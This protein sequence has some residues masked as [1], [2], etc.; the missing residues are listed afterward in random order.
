MQSDPATPLLWHFPVSHY[1][2]KAR[3]ALDWKRI[4][5]RRKAL[6][7]DYIPRAFF[8][9]RQLSLP[10]LILGGKAVADSTRI[11]ATL[12]ERWRDPPLYPADPGLREEALALEDFFD[13]EVGHPV[14]TLLLGDLSV[15]GVD[16]FRAVGVRLPL[17]FDGVAVDVQSSGVVVAFLPPTRGNAPD[18]KASI[19]WPF[20]LLADA[21]L[22]LSG[23]IS[24]AAARA[25]GD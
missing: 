17:Q 18:T 16:R 1:N 20:V 21:F 6:F 11:I 15:R 2:E 24:L 8:R 12:E 25:P 9:T 7:V 19:A 10:I 3:W 13:E 23:G 22:L 14:R 5:H 4:P